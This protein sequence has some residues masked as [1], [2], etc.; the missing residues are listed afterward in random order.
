MALFFGL[1][2][3]GVFS[4]LLQLVLVRLIGG[5]ATFGLNIRLWSIGCTVVFFGA[6]F[7][8]LL[9]NT[10]RII[11]LSNPVQLLRACLLYTSCYFTILCRRLQ[12]PCQSRRRFP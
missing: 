11:H 9:L 1:V 12:R 8:L 2:A 6:L 4:K 7:L 3:A 10:I 5:E